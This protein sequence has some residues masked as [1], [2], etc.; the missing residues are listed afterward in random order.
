MESQKGD[1]RRGP[2]EGG[3]QKENLREEDFVFRGN[4]DDFV[5]REKR[6]RPCWRHKRWGRVLRG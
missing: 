6:R 2:A 1:I 5:F 3:F 4:E